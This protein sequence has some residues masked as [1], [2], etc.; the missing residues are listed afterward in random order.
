MERIKCIMRDIAEEREGAEHYA[1]KALQYKDSDHDLAEMYYNMSRQEMNHAENLYTQGH[2]LMCK[3]KEHDPEDYE[4]MLWAWEWE[5]DKTTEEMAEARML[6][7]M[8][9]GQ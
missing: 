8:Y 1:K 5:H 6:Q 2:R 3:I 4:K 9:R 7:E